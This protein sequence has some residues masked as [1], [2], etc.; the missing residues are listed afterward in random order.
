MVF[1]KIFD[2]QRRTIYLCTNKWGEKTNCDCMFFG[3]L[4]VFMEMF[5][6]IHGEKSYFC[7]LK[8]QE[9]T[10]FVSC[11][12]HACFNLFNISNYFKNETTFGK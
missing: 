7:F 3:S 1:R 11:C 6:S 4:L 8:L 12:L 10:N 9:S 5:Y 2:F